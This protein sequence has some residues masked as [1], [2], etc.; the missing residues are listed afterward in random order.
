MLLCD[1]TC[2]ICWITKPTSK[3]LDYSAEV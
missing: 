3:C 1:S 2:V